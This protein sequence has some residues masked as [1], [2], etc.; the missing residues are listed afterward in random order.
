MS[1]LSSTS[2]TSTLEL[3]KADAGR[4]PHRFHSDFDRILI[5]GNYLR[6]ILSNGSNII[7]APAGHQSSNGSAECM[8]RTM[9]QM[10]R[11]FITENQVGRK[12][13]YFAVQHAA[14]ILNQVPGR[15]GLKLTTPFELVHNSKPDSKKWFE[16]FS[17]G[18]FN[19]NIDN[20]ESRS[21][22]QAHTLYGIAV[23]WDDRSNYI[24]FYNPITPSYYRPP[25]F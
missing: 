22:L 17:I 23:G 1:S 2:I 6:W 15:L 7:T 11:A 5:G 14:M 4:L 25:Y 12:F 16:L 19:H 20:A 24:I 13:W 3:F 18:Y 10:S 9:I 21:K 8:W